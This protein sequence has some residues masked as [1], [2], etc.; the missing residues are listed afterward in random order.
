MY[1]KIFIFVFL[2]IL[3]VASQVTS[4]EYVNN[5]L[6]K[7]KE[8]NEVRLIIIRH[9]QGIHN[10][11]DC[12]VSS[13]SPGVYLTEIGVEQVKKSAIELGEQKIDYI[14]VSPVYRTLQTAQIIGMALNIPYQKLIVDDKL[15]EQFF[16]DFEGKTW[17]EYNAYFS[18]EK[19]QLMGPPNGETDLQVWRRTL[20]SLMEI[21]K[22]HPKETILIVTHGFNYQI[23]SKI[24]IGKS[25]HPKTAEYFIFD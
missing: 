17:S 10:V 18:K 5:K 2:S 11:T 19:I 4:L 3:S 25:L 7:E 24:L 21:V 6:S 20:K 16:G 1:S 14:Y 23:I 13:L 8:M 15:R 12:I 9:G 22:K